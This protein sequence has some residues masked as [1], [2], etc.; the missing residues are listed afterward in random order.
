MCGAKSL[1]AFEQQTRSQKLLLFGRNLCHEVELIMSKIVGGLT[2]KSGQH[3]IVT[4][5]VC[6][7]REDQL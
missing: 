1:G 3:Y 6:N 2:S 4:R 7:K 5:V